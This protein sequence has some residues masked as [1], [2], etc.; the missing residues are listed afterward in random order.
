MA[1]LVRVALPFQWPRRRAV[2]CVV[3][4]VCEKRGQLSRNGRNPVHYPQINWEQRPFLPIGPVFE[5]RH[6]TWVMHGCDDLRGPS[7]VIESG[8]QSGVRKIEY[9]RLRRARMPGVGGNTVDLDTIWCEAFSKDDTEIMQRPSSNVVKVGDLQDTMPCVAIGCLRAPM[10]R[11]AA[12]ARAIRSDESP[13][14]S[15][16]APLRAQTTH[17]S[18]STLASAPRASMFITPVQSRTAADSLMWES[19]VR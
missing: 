1:A 16:V 17:S 14:L 13:P 8:E 10:Q 19:P 3:K 2:R 7:A 4:F 6:F 9:V 18:S 11:T 15:V 5:V 12:N